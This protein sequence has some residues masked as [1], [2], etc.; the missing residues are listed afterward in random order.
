MFLK[1]LNSRPTIWPA[2]LILSLLLLTSGSAAAKPAVD[3]QLWAELLEKYVKNGVVDYAGFQREEE[4][5]DRYLDVLAQQEPERLSRNARYAYYVNVYN[6]WTVKLILSGYP[7]IK[8][9]KELGGLIQ[10]PWDKE[11]VR[12]GSQTFTLDE[13]EHEILRPRFKDPRIHFVV[14]CASISCPPLRSEPYE[15]EKLEAQ[16]EDA[17]RSFL[18]GGE[19]YR[20]DGSNFY[21]SRL[22]KW[23]GEDFNNDAI[24]YYLQYASMDLKEKIQAAG[25]SLKVKYLKYDW[26]LNGQ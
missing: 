2:L 24:G 19:N 22:F 11:I 3:N 12:I 4:K 18:N 5:L 1:I 16:L 9:I 10:T 26:G 8:S 17:T 14:N 7:G 6:A 20:L 13:I 23:Y 15:A 25:S 21:V